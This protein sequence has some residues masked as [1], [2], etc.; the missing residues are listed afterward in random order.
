MVEIK[1]HNKMVIRGYNSVIFNKFYIFITD[2]CHQVLDLYSQ[3]ESEHKGHH[4]MAPLKFPGMHERTG[5]K[6]YSY[7]EECEFPY[8]NI[9]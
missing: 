6:R 2:I 7:T 9:L 5:I 8:I 1:V 3:N 4:Y